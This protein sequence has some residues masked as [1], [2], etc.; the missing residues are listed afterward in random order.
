MSILAKATVVLEGDASQL[1]SVFSAAEQQLTQVGRRMQEAGRNLSFSVTVP[2]VGLG[3]AAVRT[4]ASFDE[5][6]RKITALTGVPAQQVN[7]WRGEVESLATQYGK[8]AQD[9]AD[10][11]YFITSAGVE[12]GK[13]M[14]TLRAALEGSAVGL[15]E[16]KVIADA[17]TS[18][19]NAYS[20]QG[21]TAARATEILAAG[22]KFGKFEAANLA[23]VLGQLV[24]ISSALHISFED[25][26]GT[27]AVF[28]RTGTD[29]AEGATQL[30][31]MMNVLLGSSA[32][33]TKALKE[34]GITLEALRK[35]A[36]GPNGLIDVMRILDK[37]FGGQVD[38]MRMVIPNIRAFRGVMNALAQDTRSVNEIMDGT[39]NSVGF[40]DNAFKDV[41]GPAFR[42]QQA[43]SQ[44]KDQLLQL[45]NVLIPIV[46]PAFQ[47]VTS[48]IVSLG[49]KFQ[50][51]SPGWQSFIVK[52]LA[53]VAALGPSIVILG[54][55][56]RLLGALRFSVVISALG[57]LSGAFIGLWSA[58]KK[59]F[60]FSGIP[61]AFA[62]A[63]EAGTGLT[64]VLIGLRGAFVRL[65]GAVLPLTALQN[66]WFWT[67]IP[68]AFA[69]ASAAG[70]GLT[71]VMW[72]LRGAFLG[73]FSAA[74]PFLPAAIVVAGI[75]ALVM[76]QRELKDKIEA[77]TE[78]IR[79]QKAAADA[80]WS[81]FAPEKAEAQVAEFDRRIG[82]LSEQLQHLQTRTMAATSAQT[83]AAEATRTRATP[84]IQENQESLQ[85]QVVQLQDTIATL[86]RH[87]AIVQEVADAYA[88]AHPKIQKTTQSFAGQATWADKV[89]EI[90]EKM[91][92]SLTNAAKM[93]GLL[94]DQF[95]EGEAQI[96]AYTTAVTDLVATGVPLDLALR[97]N[98]D[99]VT[100]LAARLLA[101]K[102]AAEAAKAAQESLSDSI[103]NAKSAVED[104]QTA[105]EKYDQ[106]V[107]DLSIAF[108]AGAITYEEWIRALDHA[109]QVMDDAGKHATKLTEAMQ[110]IV[111]RGVDDF[112]D[113]IFGAKMSFRDFVR[114]ALADITK[115][116]IKLEIMKYL[117]P[118]DG[119]GLGGWLAKIPGFARGGYL[120]A[121]G[122]GIVGENGPELV[123]AGRQG[124]T[125][126]PM[127]AAHAAGGGVAADGATAVSV[128]VTV[129]A[130]DSRSVRQ[131]F[132]ENESLVANAMLRATQKST[133][134]RRR[135]GA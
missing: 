59:A 7:A 66:F 77:T 107:T 111:G 118:E 19:M 84:A 92:A 128:N 15:G 109:K 1:Y 8:T 91:D 38:K 114:E 65:V 61:G 64:G 4:A 112:V 39:R 68:G 48:W 83:F 21:L 100:G 33:G 124:L 123:M 80:A 79:A 67:G 78:A 95:D 70:T 63:A 3:V 51:L 16:T 32:E 52:S 73:M 135:L 14:D 104:S 110:E 115:L 46:I 71:G 25:V 82:I 26:V 54:T 35:V 133:A 29:A 20:K 13:A 56:S 44:L 96:S 62:A 2:I 6:M 132:D 18:A 24:G 134:L 34:Q 119:G 41:Q 101:A 47:Q 102:D 93:E 42:M 57:R 50:K 103:S 87:R 12:S 5:S 117:F 43:W 37:A 76:H 74:L 97:A 10:A 49:E 28:S 94:G 129:N 106:T 108:H 127:P 98:G 72:G 31:S 55:F 99:S 75:V 116:I 22:V 122:V 90:L 126:T 53:L 121:G 89:K 120:D 23:P 36:A 40:L 131:F 113:A 86:R 58:A 81:A 30:S 130:I 85:Q 105:A 125:V 27:L 69:A 45:G 17:A 60:F 9:A 88:A 11:L